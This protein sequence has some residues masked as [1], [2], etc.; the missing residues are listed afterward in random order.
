[1]A[2]QTLMI[3]L[4]VGRINHAV[5]TVGA[6][7]AGRLDARLIGIAACQPVQM[8]DA[9]G[10]TSGIALAEC[11]DEL[12]AEL[13]AAKA[14]FQ[15]SLKTCGARLE[16]RSAYTTEGVA[17]YLESEARCADLIVTSAA[18]VDP[19][20]ATRHAGVGSLVLRAG[21]PVL[22]VPSADPPA[23]FD[24][25]VI[26]WQDTREARRAVVDSLPLLALAKT[27]TVLEIAEQPEIAAALRRTTDVVNWLAA[28]GIPAVP[29]AETA[30]GPNHER[31]TVLLQEQGCD[32]VVAGAYG[33]SRLREWAFG[34]ITRSLLS[35]ARCA[36]LSH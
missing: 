33:H 35:G 32:L 10:Y 16:W 23:R 5:L 25:M 11:E 15:E 24:R 34:G 14:E 26:A 8:L 30:K 18:D 6:E 21:R 22:V 3:H 2:Y 28:H 19:F 36:L 17:F 31:L 20:D 1:M 7:L 4:G 29:M 12:I 13:R 27:V 9:D